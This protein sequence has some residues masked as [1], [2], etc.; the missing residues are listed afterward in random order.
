MPIRDTIGVWTNND[1]SGFFAASFYSDRRSLDETYELLDAAMKSR[2]AQIEPEVTNEVAP[3][4]TTVLL[5][6]DS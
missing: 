2:L 1:N 6:S 4:F 3:D 5:R